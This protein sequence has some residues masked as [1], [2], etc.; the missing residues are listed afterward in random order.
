MPRP[1]PAP[2]TEQPAHD[3]HQVRA[4]ELWGGNEGGTDRLS[5]PG[6][7]AFMYSRPHGGHAAGGDLRFVSTCAAG[8]IVRFTLADIAGHGQDV[9]ESAL[10]LRSLMR[11]HMNTPNP[12][13]FARLL[14]REFAA[15]SRA[16]R[17]ATAVISTYFAPTDFL[18]VCNAGHP[19][20]LLRRIADGKWILFDENAPGVLTRGSGR[21]TGIS[22]LPLGVI[23][24]TNYPQF[25][26]R[27]ENGDL[28]VSYTDALIES[29]DP[30]G[31]ELGEEGLRNLVEGLDSSDPARLGTAI[32]DSISRYRGGAPADD[33]ET[34]L[35]LRHN[36]TDPPPMP[37][38]MTIKALGHLVGLVR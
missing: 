11:K 13:K 36:A 25:A 10:R 15:M 24:P 23:D 31:R 17:F 1:S 14:N 16:G 34:L 22:N 28:F 5:V 8:K 6:F 30:A 32:L 21:E 33:D 20:P 38:H 18:I 4:M 29:K 12:T 35:V 19:R 7:D 2:T 3:I 26:T 27:L 9:S 37:F